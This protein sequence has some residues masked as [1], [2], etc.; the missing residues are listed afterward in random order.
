MVN[1]AFR[2]TSTTLPESASSMSEMY[3]VTSPLSALHPTRIN[4]IKIQV[5]GGIRS[6]DHID[7]LINFGVDTV[8]LG[9]AAVENS[10]LL[11]AACKKFSKKIAISLD[12]RE[13]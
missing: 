5:G 1:V 12:A 8:I 11:E 3:N 10:E 4:K 2:G 9:T 6:L 13:G 7:Q